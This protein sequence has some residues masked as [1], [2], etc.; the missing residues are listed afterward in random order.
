MFA[1]PDAAAV[2]SESP[3]AQAL[4]QQQAS[5][6][7]AESEAAPPRRA[8]ARDPAAV[9]EAAESEARKTGTALW[10][11]FLSALP[12]YLIVI[13]LLI[14][15][16]GL[17]RAV[18]FLSHRLSGGWERADA[19]AA[20]FGIAVWAL[21]IGVAISVLLG[22]VRALVGSVGLL[23]LA[24]SWALQAPIES[25]TGWLLNSL[26]GYYRVGDRIE[27]G[28]VF[29]DVFRIDLLTTTV[30]EI[31]SPHRPSFVRAEQP[32][33]RLITFPNSE[34]LTGSIINF[35]RDFPWVWD[36]L[37]I[38][39]AN[40]S[41]LRYAAEQIKRVA[42]ALLSF[43]MKEAIGHYRGAIQ[44]LGTG[45]QVADEPEVF[46]SL[47]ESWTDIS[48]RYLV[49]ARGRRSRKSEL[50]LRITEELARPEH[51]ARIIP[52]IPRQQ[53]QFVGADGKVR[54]PLS[55]TPPR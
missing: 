38:P 32:T 28:E 55:A 5:S 33:G 21:A 46:V 18:R 3:T 20:M 39:V 51:R 47:Q 41:D 31:G 1:G 9:V 45:G 14:L 53:L 30:W 17:T 37:A 42:D 10:E 19:F 13:A 44:E 15:G 11:A 52:A 6:A 22:D 8:E 48:V 29:G 40:E 34:I 24:L 16:W 4:A 43:E 25:F 27:V 7:D 12:R 2:E 54:E 36:E 35:T 23:G 26:R 49:P 50:T